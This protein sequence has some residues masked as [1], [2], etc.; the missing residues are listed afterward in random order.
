V[1]VE[2][3]KRMRRTRLTFL[4]L[5]LVLLSLAA[6]RGT[7]SKA[8][9][10]EGTPIQKEEPTLI[11]A[12]TAEATHVWKQP[13]SII[14]IQ[15]TPTPASS[16][17]VSADKELIERGKTLYEKNECNSCHGDSGEGLPDKG[18]KLAGTEL[19]EDEF[20]DV[21]RTGKRGELGNDHL[22][23]TSA[24]TSSGIKAVYAFLQSLAD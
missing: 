3:K 7:A 23:G 19:S 10:A 9:D 12:A 24:I 2:R 1:N 17:P 21:L 13:T 11:T 6:C 22:Y 16:T 5:I 4:L 18:A 8:T 20:E 15:S 14:K